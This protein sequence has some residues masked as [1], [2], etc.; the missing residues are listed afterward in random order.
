MKPIILPRKANS[1]SLER[2]ESCTDRDCVPGITLGITK[3]AEI[4]GRGPALSKLGLSGRKAR[5][6]WRIVRRG[7]ICFQRQEQTLLQR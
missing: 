2:G 4:T 3:D 7:A 6:R 1:L 5:E